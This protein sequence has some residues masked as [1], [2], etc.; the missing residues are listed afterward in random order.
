MKFKLNIQFQGDFEWLRRSRIRI[1]MLGQNGNLPKSIDLQEPE[2]KPMEL[3]EYQTEI[4]STEDRIRYGA[5]VKRI[6]PY[7]ALNEVCDKIESN[8]IESKN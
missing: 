1:T 6:L 4:L 2:F 5:N 3:N 7:L 8:R